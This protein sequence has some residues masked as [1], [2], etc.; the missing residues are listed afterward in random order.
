MSGAKDGQM[1]KRYFFI[2]MAVS[3]FL[4]GVQRAASAQSLVLVWS[5]EFDGPANSRPDPTKWTFNTGAGG[6]GNDELEYYTARRKNV[7]VDGNGNLV[8]QALNKKYTGPDGVSANYTSA[9]LLTQG[10]F[11]QLYGRIEARIKLPF[12]QGIWPAFWMLGD[13]INTVSWPT[14]GEVDI[15]ENIGSE[16][17]T[18]RG[19]VH[20]PGYSGG[21]GLTGAYTLPSGQ[22]FSD[23]YHVFSID[24]SPTAISFSVDGN[25]YETQTPSNAP[26]GAPW[27]FTHPFFILLNMAVGG[28]YPGNPNSNT[29]F[30]QT[31]LIDYVRIYAD[32]SQPTAIL[33]NSAT[34]SGSD[35][36]IT[37]Q[38][39]VKGA[40]ILINGKATKAE[41]GS[42]TSLVGKNAAKLIGQGQTVTVQVKNPDDEL[43]TPAMVSNN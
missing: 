6:W 26:A 17:S 16:P 12:G 10:L 43:S 5:D 40:K 39:F 11:T 37:G 33:I 1:F 4:L 8:I 9:R 15:M 27:V 41:F 22:V 36:L 32:I 34:I 29:V 35:L 31:M 25:V 28:D 14:C 20:G 21:S 19:T 3:I 13:N 2:V 30:P 7:Y 18:N 23:D 38:N 24:W 42:S